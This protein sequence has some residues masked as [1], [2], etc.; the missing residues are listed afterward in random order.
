M[1]DELKCCEFLSPL[2]V[3]VKELPLSCCRKKSS[4]YKCT[5]VLAY[6]KTCGRAYF[7]IAY[8]FKMSIVVLTFLS[9]MIQLFTYLLYFKFTNL[10][11]LVDQEREQWRIN[12]IKKDLRIRIV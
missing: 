6:P 9:V 8:H 3:N 11:E 2:G 1:I 7:E 4:D 12:E 10:L 5:K